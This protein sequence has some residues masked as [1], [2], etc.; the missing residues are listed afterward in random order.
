MKIVFI[1]PKTIFGNTWEALNIGYMSA[2]LKERGYSDVHFFSG[3]FDLDETIIKKCKDADIVGFSCTSPQ[4]KHALQLAEKIKNPKNWIVFGGVH[5]SVLPQDTLDN[6]CVDAVVVGEGEAAMLK[7]VQGDRSRIVQA[8]YIQNLDELPFPDRLL[9]KQERN[10]QQAYRDNNLRIASIFSS[11]GCPFNCAFCAS[12]CVW[13]RRVRFRSVNN[14]LD[15]FAQVVK[16][17]NID[18]IKFSDDTFG[19]QKD[20]LINFC[21][22]K[23]KRNLNTPFG[24]NIRVN[25][26]DREILEWLKKAGC[27]EL[28]AGVES[29]SP[30]ILE[31]MNKGIDIGQVKWFFSITKEMGFFRRAYILLGM[32][33]ETKDD[34]KMTEDLIDEIEPDMV[35]FTILAPYPGTSFYDP[36]RHKNVDWSLVDEYGNNL[37]EGKYLTNAE[38]VAEQKRL[39]KKYKDIITYRQKNIS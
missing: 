4:M 25:T 29:G 9:I 7:I 32:S 13:T 18:F 10:I 15:E 33:N 38:L 5:P 20:W 11:R 34:I 2:Y 1:Q 35:G 21:Q 39:V 19:L 24:C 36:V 6:K 23:I 31:E 27:K 28:W 8:P 12:H 14:V 17:L 3:F 16:D 37:V 30:K 22:E 26:A